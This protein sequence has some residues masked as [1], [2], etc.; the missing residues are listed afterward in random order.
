[1]RMEMEFSVWWWEAEGV[2]VFGLQLS[3]KLQVGLYRSDGGGSGAEE[4]RE[5][6]SERCR[7]IAGQC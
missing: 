3:L 4:Q 1:M 7:R 5:L 6:T 2:P